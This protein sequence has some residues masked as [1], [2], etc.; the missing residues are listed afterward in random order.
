[1]KQ[2]N[3]VI[4]LGFFC[5]TA[6]EIERVGLR[7]CSSPFDWTISE[8]KGVL[9]CMNND[10]EDFL[11]IENLYQ[12]K[13]SNSKYLDIRY[14][15][16]YFHDFNRYESLEN[17]LPSV[18]EKYARRIK[19]FSENIKRPT[20]FIRYLKDQNEADFIDENRD[21][22]LHT[23]KKSNNANKLLLI[24]NENVAVRSIN[25]FKVQKDKND[26]VARK[27]LY[28][29]NELYSLLQSDIYDVDMRERNLEV[30][31]KKKRR[32]MIQKV[33]HLVHEKLNYY[34]KQSYVSDKKYYKQSEKYLIL[35]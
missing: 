1:M 11:Q 7:N 31:N 23:I 29:N 35:D 2:Y 15:F 3:H 34:T 32:E 17:Q 22:V 28:K 10:F 20:L 30:Y 26:S 19:K 14:N 25:C 4:S 9:E 6:L 8:F 18:K 5:S 13:D 33:P 27:F 24:S 21:Y 12:S 16:E